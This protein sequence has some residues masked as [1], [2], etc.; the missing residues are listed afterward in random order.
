MKKA[1]EPCHAMLRQASRP[2]H[3]KPFH[4]IY[5]IRNDDLCPFFAQMR[6]YVD[7]FL[8]V[9]FKHRSVDVWYIRE[10]EYCIY[11]TAQHNSSMPSRHWHWTHSL[12]ALL[13]CAVHTKVQRSNRKAVRKRA[14]TLHYKIY[15][16]K[17][18]IIR[19]VQSVAWVPVIK[20]L[21]KSLL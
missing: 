4:R 21:F 19:P 15:I 5:D 16:P 11:S 9:W 18:I 6:A 3:L 8:C 1:S 17:G 14:H 2:D 10:C 13:Y 7:F 20:L 12:G